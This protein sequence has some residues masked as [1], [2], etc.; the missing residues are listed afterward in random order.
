MIEETKSGEIPIVYLPDLPAHNVTLTDRTLFG[1]G[2]LD[3]SARFDH[4]LG[5]EGVDEFG[6]VAGVKLTGIE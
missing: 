2:T 3:G 5:N 1:F 6:R 4:V